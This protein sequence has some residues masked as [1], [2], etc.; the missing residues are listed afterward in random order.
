MFPKN[1]PKEVIDIIF[2]YAMISKR[3]KRAALMQDIRKCHLGTITNLTSLTTLKQINTWGATLNTQL[4]TWDTTMEIIEEYRDYM[5]PFGVTDM[6]TAQKYF[7][8]AQDK[9][10][11]SFNARHGPTAHYFYMSFM[12]QMRDV[13]FC[14]D[15]NLVIDYGS[16][17]DTFTRRV[18]L[19][20]N[21]DVFFN[22]C[23]LLHQIDIIDLTKKIVRSH[24]SVKLN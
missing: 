8:Q 14:G 16:Q 2:D 6:S 23:R 9:L 7:Y 5:L 21:K 4:N 10:V 17:N 13:Q 12:Y 1:C 15:N 18:Y 19:P 11:T 20:F 3:S 24:K 22:Y